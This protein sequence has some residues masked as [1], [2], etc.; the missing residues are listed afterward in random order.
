M[1]LT[2]YRL[3]VSDYHYGAHMERDPEGDYVLYD[4]ISDPYR[5]TEPAEGTPTRYLGVYI[6]DWQAE[7]GKPAVAFVEP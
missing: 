1:A 6:L 4:D 2:R 3:S 7:W 5:A